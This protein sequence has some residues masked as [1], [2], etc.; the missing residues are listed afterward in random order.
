M[1]QCGRVWAPARLE[2]SV[3]AIGFGAGLPALGVGLLLLDDP[4]MG[5][6]EQLDHRQDVVEAEGIGFSPAIVALLVAAARGDAV[7]NAAFA[8]VAPD[9]DLQDADADLVCG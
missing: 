4:G 6:V 7:P 9:R 2:S 1:E 3:I 8:A 5:L